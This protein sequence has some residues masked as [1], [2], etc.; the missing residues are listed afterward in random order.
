MHNTSLNKSLGATSVVDRNISDVKGEITKA[1]GD[2]QV[3]FVFDTVGTDFTQNLGWDILASGGTFVSVQ[4]P[5]VDREK[6]SDKKVV[7]S[8]FGNVHYPHLRSLGVS[9]YKA[10]PRLLESGKLQVRNTYMY[11]RTRA[12]ADL[13]RNVV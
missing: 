12:I 5:K 10:L 13:N 3:D 6:Y 11:P 8:I 9:L 4:P 2:S 1:A 7:D